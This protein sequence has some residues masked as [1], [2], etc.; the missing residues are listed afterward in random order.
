MRVAPCKSPGDKGHGAKRSVVPEAVWQCGPGT[1][2]G[3]AWKGDA[4]S[5]EQRKDPS[6]CGGQ[7]ASGTWAGTAH[8]PRGAGNLVG[9]W[10]DGNLHPG[11]GLDSDENDYDDGA[12]VS[13]Q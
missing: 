2:S 1:G 11:I 8:F 13:A 7:T 5:L 3:A 6:L 9:A 10:Y 12:G 4:G